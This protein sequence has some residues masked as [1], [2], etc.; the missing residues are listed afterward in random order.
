MVTIA[1]S[2]IA[3]KSLWPLLIDSPVL[4]KSDL[5]AT[6]W[7][8]SHNAGTFPAENAHIQSCREHI[9]L[10]ASITP[11]GDYESL[12]T[13]LGDNFIAPEVFQGKAEDDNS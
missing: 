12:P 8:N 3:Q 6:S 4:V 9:L 13:P 2:R 1:A 5:L 10:M 7:Q 11:V